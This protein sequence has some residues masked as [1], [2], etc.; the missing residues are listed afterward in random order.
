MMLGRSLEIFLLAKRGELVSE[1]TI[2]YYAYWCKDFSRYVAE[3][4]ALDWKEVTAEHLQS[5]LYNELL[6]NRKVRKVT[7][8]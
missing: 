3:L 6:T 8:L 4:G 7:V 2:K 1:N 5:Y